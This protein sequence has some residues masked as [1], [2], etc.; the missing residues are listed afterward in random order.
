[1]NMIDCGITSISLL[2]ISHFILAPEITVILACH[3]AGSYSPRF[4]CTFKP[5]LYKIEPPFLVEVEIE[6]LYSPE[7]RAAI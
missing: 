4:T 3:S 2:S 7:S 1:M 5:L 6:E